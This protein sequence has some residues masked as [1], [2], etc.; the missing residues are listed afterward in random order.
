M[1][2]ITA[3]GGHG[4]DQAGHFQGFGQHLVVGK[5][6]AD[7]THD[8]CFRA[9]HGLAGQQHAHGVELAHGA[10]QALRAADAGLAKL[11]RQSQL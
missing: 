2:C 1:I 3:S 7:Q 8:V 9:A 10:H 11:Q 5:N 6:L 4:G